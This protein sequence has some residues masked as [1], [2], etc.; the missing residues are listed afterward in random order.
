VAF[1]PTAKQYDC[2]IKFENNNAPSFSEKTQVTDSGVEFGCMTTPDFEWF[3]DFKKKSIEADDK[4]LLGPGVGMSKAAGSAIGFG[5][6][7]PYRAEEGFGIDW[8]FRFGR[9]KIDR[10]ANDFKGFE[11]SANLGVEYTVPI[12]KIA[13]SPNAGLFFEGLKGKSNQA[14]GDLKYSLTGGGVYVGVK[15]NHV[16]RDGLDGFVRAFAGNKSIM[17]FAASIGYRF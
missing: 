9:H 2:K 4:N 6:R 11:G 3:L 16:S 1:R 14:A 8:G 10:G 13:F 5:F 7:S 15:V 17:G 12:D